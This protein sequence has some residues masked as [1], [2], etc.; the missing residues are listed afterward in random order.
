MI[1]FPAR[2][3]TSFHRVRKRYRYTHS[4]NAR[5]TQHGRPAQDESEFLTGVH[6]I[7]A[8]RSLSPFLSSSLLLSLFLP[9][10]SRRV[11]K[12]THLRFIL[13]PL[14]R[15]H[16]DTSQSVFVFAQRCCSR[17][18]AFSLST[19]R[20]SLAV[21]SY[22]CPRLFVSRIPSTQVVFFSLFL[23][24][25]PV[26]LSLPFSPGFCISLSFLSPDRAFHSKIERHRA[27]RAHF[28]S[29][30]QRIPTRWHA[31]ARHKRALVS[32]S[33]LTL[34]E[35]FCGLIDIQPINTCI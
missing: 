26:S 31:R 1:E 27:C 25:W 33:N 24:G 10:F 15:A 3:Y 12:R 20:F 14:I 2:G 8:A 4:R 19:S 11:S 5:E 34:C 30:K 32:C 13:F 17:C 18:V 28:S 6:T 29:W 35:K 7:T 9:A 22:V 16:T 21:C 23:A